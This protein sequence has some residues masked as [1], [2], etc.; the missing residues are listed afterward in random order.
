MSTDLI[1]EIPYAPRKTVYR[2]LSLQAYAPDHVKYA[3]NQYMLM[4][5]EMEKKVEQARKGYK[6]V[7]NTRLTV[8]DGEAAH[9]RDPANMLG[10]LNLINIST[11]FTSNTMKPRRMLPKYPEVLQSP[12]QTSYTMAVF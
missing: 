11:K 8:Y 10:T 3:C 1:L 4:S 6:K 7:I 12:D 5:R 2:D 9:D